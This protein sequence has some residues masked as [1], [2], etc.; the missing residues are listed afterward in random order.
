VG[1]N[2]VRTSVPGQRG[3]ILTAKHITPLDTRLR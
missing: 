1:I 2:G 3:E